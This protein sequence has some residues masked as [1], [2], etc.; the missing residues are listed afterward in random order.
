MKVILDLAVSADGYIAKLDGDSSWVA[1][2]TEDL[3]KERISQL[4]AL[5]VGKTSF[6]QYRDVIYPVS[7]ALNI[8]L[9]KRKSQSESDENVFYASSVEEAMQ[10]V[11]EHNCSGLLIAGGAS[12]SKSF[13]EK[14]LID[15]IYFSVHPIK[16]GEGM[17][18]FG[19]L[20][21]PSNLKLLDSKD[22]G[23]GIRQDHYLVEK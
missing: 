4:G 7:S 15:E 22:L 19:N 3:F 6:D 12:V 1:E 18:P 8:V 17:T 9:S 14:N 5:V 16:L 11:L 21:I 23:N 10:I 2:I 20:S 13:L